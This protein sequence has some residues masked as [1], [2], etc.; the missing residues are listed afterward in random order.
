MTGHVSRVDVRFASAPSA[1]DDRSYPVIIGH[2]VLH[3]LAAVVGDVAP[4]ARRAALVTQQPVADA[5][6][7]LGFTCDPGIEHRW[8]TIGDGE[9]HKRLSTVESLCEQWSAWGMTRN[10]L[11]VAVGGGIVTDV[12]GFAASCYYRGVKVVYVSTTLLGMIDAAVGGKTGVNLATGKNLVGAF[13]QPAAVVCDLDTLAT[14]PSRE[15]ACGFGEMAKYH[16]LGVDHLPELSLHDQV[17]R[18]VEL[19]ARVVGE[20]EREG[21]I[22]ATLN[23][24][25]TLA[26][27]M[28]TVGDHA[29]RHGEAVAIGLVYAAELARVLGRISDARVD[30]HRR[31]VRSF[32]LSVDIPTGL[33]R[34]LLIGAMGRDKK[35]LTGL[36]FVLDG[37]NGVETVSGVQLSAVHAAFDAMNHPSS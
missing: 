28:E 37:P 10:D 34:T 24:G 21:G 16:F 13:W 19:K 25:H 29:L 26:H 27:A 20:D 18:C 5:L 30:E 4:Q 32:D 7:G 31:V 2:G 9:H 1:V 8:F 6:A 36:T 15:Q 17:T 23:Y 33:D 14:M 3:D 22:R 35:A 11:V 12:G